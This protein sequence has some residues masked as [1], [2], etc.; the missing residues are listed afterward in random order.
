MFGSPKRNKP[1]VS[2]SFSFILFRFYRPQ[3]PHPWTRD[4]SPI[5]GQPYKESALTPTDNTINFIC[6][7]SGYY[8]P[9]SL[10]KEKF[11]KVIFK[12]Q[13]NTCP[14]KTSYTN[15]CSGIIHKVETTQMSVMDTWINKTWYIYTV[16]YFSAV[17]CNEVLIRATT[18][19]S[20]ENIKL[21][22]RSQS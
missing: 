3:I 18:W 11:L 2:R 20:L 13:W 19:M 14:H 10:F 16:E 6:Y 1:G 15:D 7:C 17:K 5:W 4:K 12:E 9:I 22:E 21:S 8:H